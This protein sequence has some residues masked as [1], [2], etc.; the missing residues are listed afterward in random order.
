MACIDIDIID[1]IDELTTEELVEELNGRR[2]RGDTKA[3]TNG[4]WREWERLADFIAQGDTREALYLLAKLAPTP[5]TPS[6]TLF[7]RRAA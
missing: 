7:L 3:T 6:T 5:I 1:Y 4:A 2:E